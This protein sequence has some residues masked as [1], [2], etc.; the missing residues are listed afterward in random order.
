ME[1]LGHEVERS[2]Y[3][4]NRWLTSNQ[5]SKGFVKGEGGLEGLVEGERGGAEILCRCC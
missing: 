5:R 2:W 1:F 4:P 3:G